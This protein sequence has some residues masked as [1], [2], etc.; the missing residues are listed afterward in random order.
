MKPLAP[1]SWALPTPSTAI[2]SEQQT[3]EDLTGRDNAE[4]GERGG[5][6]GAGKAGGDKTLSQWRATSRGCANEAMQARASVD[7]RQRIKALLHVAPPT[8]LI[9]GFEKERARQERWVGTAK[10]NIRA[11][12]ELGDAVKPDLGCR[13]MTGHQSIGWRR[14]NRALTEG[15]SGETYMNIQMP[16]R[17]ERGTSCIVRAGWGEGWN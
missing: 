13:L 11:Q 3:G 9:A 15:P 17:V 4:E 5:A 2:A 6:I 1:V 14:H 7:K 16:T 8:S 10:C 12:V